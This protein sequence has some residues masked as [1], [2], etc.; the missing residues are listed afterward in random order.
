GVETDTDCGGA[1]D[2]D[3]C[4]DGW[5]CLNGSDFANC[6][7]NV[8]NGMESDTDCGGEFCPP[9]PDTWESPTCSDKV[10]NGNETDKDCGGGSCPKCAVNMT[11]QVKNDCISD[12][13]TSFIC[14]APSCTDQVM[15]GNETDKDCGGGVCV[16]CADGLHCKVA[17]DCMSGVC[18]NGTC[19]VPTC[20][21]TVK[22]GNETD[23]DCGGGTCP[24]CDNALSCR[25]DT[26]CV[27][28]Q[29]RQNVCQL[30]S[31]TS[32]TNGDFETG[33]SSGWTIG[34]GSRA[35]IDS[36]LI[37]PSD[38]LLGGSRYVANIA[39]S[40]S[41]IVTS[42]TDPNIKTLMPNIVHREQRPWSEWGRINVSCGQHT[43][44][45][46]EQVQ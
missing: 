34:G 5:K 8:K 33:T 18:T 11:C 27:S 4:D 32:F 23:K 36:S 6:S 46:I 12:V 44:H 13:C 14:R 1:G 10:W 45:D 25:G 22:N 43:G 15:N 16:P 39:T 31:L 29:C 7:D 17:S 28:N 20:N 19:Q 30:C 35:G 41:S 24:K 21:D 2:C 42:G 38:Y 3:R 9:C 40:H 26:D 37:N